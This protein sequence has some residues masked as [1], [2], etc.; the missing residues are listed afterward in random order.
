MKIIKLKDGSAKLV[1]EKLEKRGKVHIEAIEPVVREIVDNVKTSGD[2]ALLEYTKR[3]DKVDLNRDE[4]KVSP[5]ELKEAYKSLKEEEVEALKSAARNIRIHHSRQMR[6]LDFKET[7]EGVRVAQVLRPIRRVGIYVPGGKA[8]YPSSVL[9]TVIP[10]KVAGVKEIVLC[11]PP[12]KN[13]KVNSAVLVAA[14][15]AGADTI[16][17]VG[18]A[19]AISA[20]AYGTESIPI[21]DKIVGPGNIY[22]TAAKIMVSHDVAIDNP[23]GPS[24]IMVLADESAD[25]QFIAIDLI[26]QCEH[27]SDAIALLVTVSDEL[28]NKVSEQV[29]RMLKSVKRVEFV[30]EALEKNCWI[31]VSGSIEEALQLVN[32]LAPEHLEVMVKDPFTV[33]E[34]VENAGAVF[35]G[36]YTP[37]AVGDYAAGSNHVLPVGGYAR[38]F[39]GL[40]IRDFTKTMDVV[41]CSRDGL[42]NLEKTVS[43]LAFLEGLEEHSKSVSVRLKD[44]K[45]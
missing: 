8:V 20:M 45:Q 1:L 12:D 39:S 44:E 18:G 17:K 10:A 32:R 38:V 6:E 7:V 26:A 5:D 29:Y 43:V 22:V 13:G 42:R 2:V 3:F 23:A 35:L 37:V 14:Q 11:T 34:K 40:S 16:F 25:P 24:E 36:Q 41:S 33:L 9:M 30:N 4:L 21:V 28:A 27:G 15:E 19:Q 31:F